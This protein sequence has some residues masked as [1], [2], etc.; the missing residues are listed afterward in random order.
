M[1]TENSSLAS[2][3]LT[4]TVPRIRSEPIKLTVSQSESEPLTETVPRIG[5]ESSA[6]YIINKQERV[7]A[8]DRLQKYST[9]Q[10]KG[11]T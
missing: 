11:E 6:A 7:K 9:N 1:L 10:F 3:P 2:E 8:V 5:N 4:R